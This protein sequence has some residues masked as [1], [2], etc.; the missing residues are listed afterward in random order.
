MPVRRAGGGEPILDASFDTTT[1][2]YGF[3][4]FSMGLALFVCTWI[5]APSRMRTRVLALAGFGALHSVFI[6]SGLSVGALEPTARF[7]IGAISFLLLWAFALGDKSRF[8]SIGY[9]ALG[10]AAGAWCV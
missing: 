7:A 10:C 4:F 1:A 3:A 6:W 8:S 2:V 9:G 5:S